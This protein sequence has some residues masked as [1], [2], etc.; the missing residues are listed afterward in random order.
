MSNLLAA[1]GSSAGALD[2]LQQA[3]GVIQNN[4]SNAST[5]GYAAQRLG[6]AARPLDVAAGAAGG[7]ASQGLISSRDA[8]ADS[9]VRRQ[10]QLLG[11]Y[12]AQAQSTSTIQNFF[13]VSGSSGVSAALT[14]LFASFS[15]LSASPTDP[16]AQQSVISNAAAFASSVQGLAQSLNATAGKLNQQISS[17]VDQIN[18]LASQIQQYNATRLQQDQ[19]DPGAE[20]NLESTLESLSR[21]TD[22]TALRQADGTI[23]VLA[24]GGEPLVIGNQQ[25]RISAG[26]SVNNNPPAA[27]PQSAPTAHVF[28]SQ[29]RDITGDIHGGQLGGLLDSR[30]RVLSSI[31]GDAQQTGSL[32]TLAKRFADTVN[33]ILVSGKVSTETGAAQGVPLFSY[34]AS[35]ATNAAGSLTVNSTITADQIAPVDAAGNANGNAN[36]LAALANSGNPQ[37]QIEGVDFTSFYAGIAAAAGQEN[38]TAQQNSEVQQQV[39]SQAQSLRDQISGVSLDSQAAQVLEFQ[40][41]YQAVARVLTVVNSL[42]DSILSLVPQ[43]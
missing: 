15:A 37:A 41:A 39:L 32:N 34:D 42:A 40:R 35:N 43:A 13:D 2:V 16:V 26:I 3:L 19:P 11:Q 1:I 10:L 8:Y 28:D 14:N 38:Q 12:T 17:T 23:T 27:N 21:L 6:I 25:Y 30:N 4:V 31:I 7:I 18:K 5:P 9:E 20:A 36:A 22:F 24:S 33:S 29:G